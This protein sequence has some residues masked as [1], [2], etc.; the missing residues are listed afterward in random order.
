MLHPRIEIVLVR[1]G[2]A[3]MIERMKARLSIDGNTEVDQ[4]RTRVPCDEHIIFPFQIAMCNPALVDRFDDPQHLFEERVRI[5]DR[6]LPH[7]LGI[8]VFED[9]VSVKKE[10]VAV[11]DTLDTVQALIG[12]VL[13]AQHPFVY[14]GDEARASRRFDK[15]LVVANRTRVKAAL[16]AAARQPPTFF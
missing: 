8:N 6:G 2:V 9:Q 15:D 13:V 4:A 14:P 3:E 7:R 1:K 12:V 11:R 16:V 10:T 5:A